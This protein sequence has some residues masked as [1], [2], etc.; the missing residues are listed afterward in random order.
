MHVDQSAVAAEDAG[1]GLLTSFRCRVGGRDVGLPPAPRRLIVAVALEPGGLGRGSLQGRLWPDVESA[2]A[3]KRLRQ[4]L[5]RVRRDTGERLLAVTPSHVALAEDVDVDLRRGERLARLVAGG[6]VAA[7]Q[8]DE[9]ELLGG[10]LLPCWPD[11][12]VWG[13]RDRWNLLRLL[14]LERLAGHALAAG[15]VTGAI[16]LAEAAARVDALSEASHRIMAAVHLARGD[17]VSAWRVFTRYRRLL[18]EEM[19]LEP[20]AEFRGLLE[21]P[22]RTLVS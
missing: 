5:W 8:P 22:G 20:S 6:T 21:S 18:D 16:D 2:E 10:E 9:V 1:L 13:V 3:A 14:A 17:Q 7:A 12:D 4:A 19:G 15:D 11:E